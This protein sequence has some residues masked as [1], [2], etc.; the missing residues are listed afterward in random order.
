[1]RL[2]KQAREAARELP[3]ETKVDGVTAIKNLRA[4]QASAC[5]ASAP[6]SYTQQEKLPVIAIAAKLPVVN[7]YYANGLPK[8]E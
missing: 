2:A 1:M 4:A 7:G 6:P 8:F 5:R 3:T